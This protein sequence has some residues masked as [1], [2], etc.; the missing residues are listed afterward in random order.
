MIIQI[1]VFILLPL[2]LHYM[3]QEII[4]IKKL[5][6]NSYQ[7][8]DE[9]YHVNYE[10]KN[11]FIFDRINTNCLFNDRLVLSIII[12]KE[13]GLTD[14]YIIQSGE[15]TKLIDAIGLEKE[16]KLLFSS[17]KSTTKLSKKQISK[18]LR[19]SVIKEEKNDK[20]KF[21]VIIPLNKIMTEN[22]YLGID[23]I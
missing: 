7:N 21:E 10:D 19:K 11:N 4:S 5:I 22:E 15:K 17:I 6:L 12:K 20:V 9:S 1:E 14:E 2:L 23:N 18:L 13:D 3:S 16:F 8:Q